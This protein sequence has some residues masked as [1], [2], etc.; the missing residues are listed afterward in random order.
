MR[1]RSL[2][3]SKEKSRAFYIACARVLESE[4]CLTVQGDENT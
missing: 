2:Y 1:D 3:A 4:G